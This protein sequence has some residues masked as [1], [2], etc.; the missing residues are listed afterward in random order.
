MD[1][2][3]LLP[4]LALNLYSTNL[5]FPNGITPWSTGTHLVSHAYIKSH[6]LWGH[7][8]CYMMLDGSYYVIRIFLSIFMRALGL[9]CLCQGRPLF[10]FAPVAVVIQGE[11]L[12]S[13]LL[14]FPRR[15][16]EEFV[17]ILL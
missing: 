2:L 3:K 12:V 6:L 15:Y 11:F 4:L 16:C 10:S 8:S 13:T 7:N 14:L 1:S 5:S 9:W 17:S